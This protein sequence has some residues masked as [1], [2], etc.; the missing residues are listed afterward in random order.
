MSGAALRRAEQERDES[1]VAGLGQLIE[2]ERAA[3]ESDDDGDDE[4]ES[5]ARAPEWIP[6][7]PNKRKIE[8]RDGRVWE[9]DDPDAVIAAFND[10]THADLM[11]DWD[12]EGAEV[13]SLWS[14]VTRAPA[15]GWIKELRK[16]GKRGIEGRV[17]WTGQGRASVEGKEYRYISPYFQQTRAE[18]DED[19]KLVALPKVQRI[20][21]AAL[22]NMPALR[23][24]AL[25]RREQPP[26]QTAATA[27]VT[28]DKA[29]LAA[30]GLPETGTA[31]QA[32]AKIVELKVPTPVDP[33]AFVPKADYDTISAELAT[34]RTALTAAETAATEVADTALAAEIETALDAAQTARKIAPE[35]RGFWA[36][37]CKTDGGL[38]KFKTQMAT[39]APVI[40]VAPRSTPTLPTAG[41]VTAASLTPQE[42]KVCRRLNLT[43]EQ[44]A[45]TRNHENEQLAAALED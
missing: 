11:V 21:N 38:A 44:Y 6:L 12:H 34:A 9:M 43:H 5:V 10:D 2:F 45:K 35:S 15:A 19:G 27:E 42:R 1:L 24:S 41:E 22:V 36:D 4:G 18:Y 40:P 3:E 7:F 29:I 25:T 37:F 14:S 33:S 16:K 28:M 17:E 26:T 39:T 32:L 30:L 13:G 8:A 23:M 20:L 31:A